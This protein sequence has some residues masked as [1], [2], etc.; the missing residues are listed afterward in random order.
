M[1]CVCGKFLKLERYQEA[2]DGVGGWRGTFFPRVLPI[3]S[4]IRFRCFLYL[5]LPRGAQTSLTNSKATRQLQVGERARSPP[6]GPQALPLAE[7]QAAGAALG[8]DRARGDARQPGDA[9]PL[10][11]QEARAFAA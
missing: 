1:T 7:T 6:S 11:G 5:L 2:A 4:N 8:Q 10:Q 3:P 9:R